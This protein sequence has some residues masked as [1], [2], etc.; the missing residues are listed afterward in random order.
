[1]PHMKRIFAELKPLGA[2]V[3]HFGTGTAALLP[4]MQEA[5]G[6]VMGVDW[7]TSLTSAS[8]SLKP[9]ALQGNLDPA[10]LLTN[11]T[12]VEREALKIVDEGR[13]VPGH[14][15]NLGHGIYPDTPLE[16]VEMLV[17]VVQQSVVLA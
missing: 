4:T 14:I 9:T 17:Q 15:F 2:P 5:G 16:N 10:I 6:D 8:K 13:T 3:I 12:I 11:P 1:M 7:R